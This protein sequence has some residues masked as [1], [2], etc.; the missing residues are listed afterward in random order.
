MSKYLLIIGVDVSKSVIDVSYKKDSNNESVYLGRYS[1][2]EAGFDNCKQSLRELTTVNEDTWFLCFE[3]TGVYSK[4]LLQWSIQNNILCKEEDPIRISR[5]LGIRRGKSDKIDSKAITQYAYEKQDSLTPSSLPKPE[6]SKIK[7]LLSRRDL[8]V[9]HKT[10]LQVSLKEQNQVL[11]DA[12]LNDLVE[13]NDRLIVVYKEQIKN[14]EKQIK[15]IID[16]DEELHR[17]D[18][19]I[20]SVV[21]IGQITSAHILSI[22]NNFREFKDAKKF[23][24]YCGVAPFPNSSG[25]RNGR[26]KVS[27]MANKK[28]KSLLSNCILSTIR[29]DSEIMRYYNRKKEEGKES[30]VVLNAIKN[31]LIQRVFAVV[32]RGTPYVKLM[33]YA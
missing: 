20:Q 25:T 26:T 23:A 7:K 29:Y 33:T 14:I 24:C 21:G 30:G 4:K 32:K 5:S 18:N 9:K 8:L 15:S 13:A 6:L 27:Q 16:N 31:K 10:A 28:M 19:L 22:T 11:E 3:N 1:N 17:N 12:L 2:N